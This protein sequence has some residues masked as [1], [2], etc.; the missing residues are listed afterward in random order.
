MLSLFKLKKKSKKEKNQDDEKEN[1]SS[2]TKVKKVEK[3][4]SSTKTEAKHKENTTQ[5]TNSANSSES[6]RESK[7]SK[8]ANDSSEESSGTKT[9]QSGSQH[10]AIKNVEMADA[11]NTTPQS[12]ARQQQQQLSIEVTSRTPEQQVHQQPSPLSSKSGATMNNQRVPVLS[13]SDAPPSSFMRG[14][15]MTSTISGSDLHRFVNSGYLNNGDTYL[16]RAA[17]HRAAPKSPHFHRPPNFSYNR[18]PNYVSPYRSSHNRVSTSSSDRASR[19]MRGRSVSPS[20]HQAQANNTTTSTVAHTVNREDGTKITTTTTTIRSTSTKPVARPVED[21]E[22]I[23][24]SKFS[25]GYAPDP[26]TPCKIDTLD[27]PAPPYPAAVPELRSRSS[28]NRRAPTTLDHVVAPHHH[29]NEDSA[30]SDSEELDPNDD[31]VKEALQDAHNDPAY[32]QYLLTHGGAL[33]GGAGPRTTSSVASSIARAKA[34]RPNSRF[35]YQNNLFDNDYND[36]LLRYKSN[37]EFKKLLKS[38]KRYHSGGESEEN[39]KEEEKEVEEEEEEFGSPA[40]KELETKIKKDIEE[41]SKIEKESSMAA[42]VL[43]ELKTQEKMLAR[44]LKLD[45]WKAS[46]APNAK[47]EIPIKTR[48]DSPINASPSRI[49]NGPTNR[50][51]TLSSTMSGHTF[52]VTPGPQSTLAS[53]TFFNDTT[54]GGSMTSPQSANTIG[55]S[56]T[57]TNNQPSSSTP[58][59]SATL[60]VNNNNFSTCSNASSSYL[61]RNAYVNSSSRLVSP[62]TNATSHSPRAGLHIPNNIVY[63]IPVPKPGYGLS[64]QNKS[65]TLPNASRFTGLSAYQPNDVEMTSCQENPISHNSNQQLDFSNISQIVTVNYYVQTR[66]NNL[67]AKSTPNLLGTPQIYPYDQLKINRKK[68]LPSSVDRNHLERHLSDKEFKDI[69]GMDQKSFYQLSEWKRVELKKKAKLF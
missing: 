55:S 4:K 69:F 25:G 24:L 14:N 19:S 64:N 3:S 49:Y 34:T 41:I 62:G 56:T 10:E 30:D 66:L 48:Y 43:A 37:K 2:P 39:E 11:T 1:T 31:E 46:R 68:K 33:G 58:N 6:K 36:Y 57:V 20:Q 28:S 16:N 67:S 27:W 5:Q 23:R 9:R 12:P 50:T 26:L 32:Q 15:F 52:S 47:C 22:P 44:K 51:Y 18:P 54:G 35:K 21:E 29:H 13:A 63:N 45:P 61:N 65:V 7:K 42:A 38:N 59:K 60:P 17:E 53:S 8:L 40:V